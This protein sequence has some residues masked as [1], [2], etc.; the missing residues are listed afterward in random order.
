MV[1]AVALRLLQWSSNAAL[2]ND[3]PVFLALA[4]AL[5]DG[6]VRAALAHEFHPLY[7]AAI[8]L[9]HAALGRPAGWSLE[10]SAV[11]ASVLASAGAVFALHALVR[12]AFG[13]E[14]AALAAGLLAVHAGAVDMGAD[15]QSEGLYLALFLG[16]AAALFRALRAVSP[17]WAAAAGVLCGLAYL[18]RPEGLTLAVVGGGLAAGLLARRRWAPRAAA[19]FTL[20]LGLGVAA[21]AFPYIGALY[22]ETG[23]LWLTRK[24]SVAWVAGVADA[25][26]HFVDQRRE[27]PWRD[28]RVPPGMD[29]LPRHPLPAS[30]DEPA[31]PPAA[32][33]LAEA[34]ADLAQSFLRALRYELL[35][36]LL[37]GLYAVR[38]RPGLRGAFLGAVLAVHA[39]LLFALARNVGYVSA[40]HLLAPAAV[41]LGYVACSAAPLAGM[42]GRVARRPVREA[43]AALLPLAL[44]GGISLGRALREP[45]VD[46]LAQRE[47]ALWLHDHVAEPGPVCA[48]K[49]RVA[50]Y[51]GAPYVRLR[52]KSRPWLAAR[53]RAYEVGHV[54]VA[55]DDVEDHPGMAELIPAVLVPIHRVSRGDERVHVLRVDGAALARELESYGP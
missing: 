2:Q 51:A 23:E 54:I 16:T 11:C 40:R 29:I 47:A 5:L 44:V 50:Y 14:R 10:T 53:L 20:A 19:A 48:E 12:P 39:V 13:P 27:P 17:A 33:S 41:L 52:S 30:L 45:D 28:G 34:A 7:P 22:A 49:R 15:V 1:A 38:G 31:S 18:T 24:K 46:V 26:A 42:L 25:P 36:F 8:A 6:D 32:P 43:V 55:D 3:G 21:L 4:R 9:V 35:V 37:L